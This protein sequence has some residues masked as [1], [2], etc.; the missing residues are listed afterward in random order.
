MAGV[1][2]ATTGVAATDGVFRFESGPS[3]FTKS[4]ET[5]VSRSPSSYNTS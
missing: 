3:R 2:A 1:A 5:F 4:A